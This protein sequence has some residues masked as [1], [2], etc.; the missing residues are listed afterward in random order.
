MPSATITSQQRE[1]ATLLLEDGVPTSWVAEDVGLSLTTVEGFITPELRARREP[2]RKD[3]LSAWTSIK[4]NPTLLALHR[5]FTTRK[6]E[7]SP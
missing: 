3:W 4:R 7:E 2:S 6:R 5:E 1:R